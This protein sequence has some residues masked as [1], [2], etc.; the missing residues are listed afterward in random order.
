VGV[1][2]LVWP[3][4]LAACAALASVVPAAG[5]R[6]AAATSD[7]AASLTGPSV[8][9]IGDTTTYTLVVTNNGPDTTDSPISVGFAWQNLMPATEF[10]S[11]EGPEQCTYDRGGSGGTSSLGCASSPA[12]LAV[13]A[14]MVVRLSLRWTQQAYIKMDASVTAPVGDPDLT[15]N[16]GSMWILAAPS[17]PEGGGGGGGVSPPV[18]TFNFVDQ[19]PRGE[20]YRPYSVDLDAC[21]YPGATCLPQGY[22]STTLA[23]GILPPGVKLVNGA[24]MWGTPTT[25]GTYSFTIAASQDFGRQGIATSRHDYT[26][27]IDPYRDGSSPIPTLTLPDLS[28]TPGAVNRAVTQRTIQ[29][30]ICVS[31]WVA[32]V[33]P[34]ASYTNRLKT[35]QMKQY[36]ETGRPTAY[37]EDF[38]IPLELGGAPRSPKNLWP[39]PHSQSKRSN[40]FEISLKR[41]VCN[42]KLTL[43][44]AR[45]G[46]VAFKRTHG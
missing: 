31:G 20:Q 32:R 43:A 4:V 27:V 8:V 9:R 10:M 15:N 37:E 26:V 24:Q 18:A 1:R 23:G 22:V 3:T 46:I 39:E 30:T 35:E 28:R 42:G 29:S 14:T 2:L 17:P 16:A 40:A 12:G 33:R 45:R 36:G 19:V 38:L 7:V 13:G 11:Y 44:T 41:R 21:N 6:S 5:S 34:P 25:P